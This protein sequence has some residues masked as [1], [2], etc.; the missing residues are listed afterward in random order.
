MSR[1]RSTQTREPGLS[2]SERHLDRTKFDYLKVQKSNP[3][4]NSKLSEY[5]DMESPTKPGQLMYRIKADG[6]KAGI[7][8]EEALLNRQ[9]AGGEDMVLLECDIADK[10]AIMNRNADEALRRERRVQRRHKRDI[11]G[12]Q[13]E[14]HEEI[15]GGVL[16]AS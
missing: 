12:G 7:S 11:D 3:N 1:V 8:D 9:L 15:Q 4:Y 5:L 13:V 2:I 16:S 14:E 6:G 10:R